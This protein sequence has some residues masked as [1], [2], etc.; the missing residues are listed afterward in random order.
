MIETS[1]EP[2]TRSQ[3]KALRIAKKVSFHRR[4][5][6][7]FIRVYLAASRSGSEREQSIDINAPS[8]VKS[9]GSHELYGEELERRAQCSEMMWVDCGDVGLHWR[10]I[11]AFIK[12]GDLLT[13]H[14]GRDYDT[15]GYMKDHGLHGDRLTLKI[16]RGAKQFGFILHSQCCGDNTARMIKVNG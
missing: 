13:I 11:A 10:S 1:Y 5:A 6:E 7:S 3:V 2:L 9:A 16:K 15:N 14:W 12:A 4:P 8:I